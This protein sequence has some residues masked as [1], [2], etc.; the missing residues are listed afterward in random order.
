MSFT[1]PHTRLVFKHLRSLFCQ[2]LGPPTT[3]TTWVSP[4]YVRLTDSLE[5]QDAIL[6]WLCKLQHHHEISPRVSWNYVYLNPQPGFSYQTIL[7]LTHYYIIPRPI[8]LVKI[9]ISFMPN[10]TNQP[11]NHDSWLYSYQAH[12]LQSIKSNDTCI[13]T[14]FML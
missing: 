6:T 1:L 11:T 4:L 12:Q 14:Y 9:H 2:R 5:F 8:Q 13:F 7:Y 3:L 10:P